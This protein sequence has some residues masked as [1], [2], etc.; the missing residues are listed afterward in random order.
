MHRTKIVATIGPATNTAQSLLALHGE[1]MDVARLNASHADLDWH[2]NT[3]ALIK[4]TL[5]GVPILLDIPGRKIRTIQLAH[6]PSF[7]VGD[8]LVLTTDLDHD[9]SQKVP[10]NYASLHEDLSA[11]NTILADDG[12]LKFTVEAVVG[13]DIICIAQTPGTLKSRKGIN[14]PFVTLRTQLVTERDRQMVQFARECGVDYLGTSFV[15]SAAHIEAIR[16]IIG[17]AMPQI[18]SKVE[19]QGGLDNLE[20][21]ARATDAIM[22]DRGDLS[23]ETNLQRLALFQKRILNTAREFAKP[24]IVATEMLHTMIENSFPTKAE[25]SDITNAV[26]DGAAATMLSGET[27]AGQHPV[28]AVKVMREVADAAS[29]HMQEQFDASAEPVNGQE[30]PNAMCE[31]ISMLCR[32]L[33]ITKIVAVTISGYAAR[34][35]AATQPRQP[36]LAV[37]NDAAAARSFNLYFGTRGIHVP[38]EFSKTDT[39]HIPL[40]LKT[41]WHAGDLSDDDLVLVTSVGY[42]RSGNRMNL[43]ETH[44]VADLVET[45]GWAR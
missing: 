36:I 26:L 45:L 41:L 5:P 22:I 29:Q 14:V 13:H 3:I 40:C 20:E 10:V 1:G 33:P 6:E 23:V 30:I 34:S 25:V 37:S 28:A 19:N 12:T 38:V 16:E 35:I 42:P 7:A 4:S 18:V 17:Q 8:K 15:E 31:A 11:G 2:R 43:I 24:V 39:D 27:A 32:A 21:V 9:G 44:R